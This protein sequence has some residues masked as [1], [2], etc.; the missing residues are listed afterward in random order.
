MLSEAELRD[1]VPM[2]TREEMS[3]AIEAYPYTLERAL[4]E[5]SDFYWGLIYMTHVGLLF[6]PWRLLFDDITDIIKETS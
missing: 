3:R 4:K 1:L 6:A 2:N 5:D